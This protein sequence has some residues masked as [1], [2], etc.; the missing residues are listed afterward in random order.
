MTTMTIDKPTNLLKFNIREVS[1]KR[2]IRKI[3]FLDKE[4]L[5]LI[6]RRILKIFEI[7]N[8]E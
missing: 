8:K 7:K 2:I 4:S 3:W 6:D 5:S 1:K